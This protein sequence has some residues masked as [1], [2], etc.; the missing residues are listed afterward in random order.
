[1]ENNMEVMV[2]IKMLLK[3]IKVKES[4]MRL[5]GKLL[6]GKKSGIEFK[7]KSK[8]ILIKSK[9]FKEAGLY[10]SARIHHRQGSKIR[11]VR[12]RDRGSSLQC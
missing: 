9:L 12:L 2:E 6:S 3:L 4:N 1:M 5:L 10:V 7:E 11:S 8:V